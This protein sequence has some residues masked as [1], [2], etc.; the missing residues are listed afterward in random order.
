MC[1]CLGLPNRRYVSFFTVSGFQDAYVL[2]RAPTVG[3]ISS[4]MEASDMGLCVRAS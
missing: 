1:S 3:D 4:V 2:E